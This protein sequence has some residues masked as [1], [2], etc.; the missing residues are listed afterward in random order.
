[1]TAFRAAAPSLERCIGTLFCKYSC[2]ALLQHGDLARPAPLRRLSRM[3]VLV[4]GIDIMSG[5][6]KRAT[7]EKAALCTSRL[8]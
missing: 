6:G 7:E 1:M 8:P 2:A 5:H 3:A 4:D